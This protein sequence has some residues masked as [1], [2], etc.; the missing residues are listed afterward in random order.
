MQ[1]KKLG[2]LSVY[3]D[4]QELIAI[5]VKDETSRK[6]V[7]YNVSEAGLEDIELLLTNKIL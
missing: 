4:K 7:I 1:T 5:V 2:V 6:N 3:N